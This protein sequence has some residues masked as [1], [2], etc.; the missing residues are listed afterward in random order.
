MRIKIFILCLMAPFV[1]LAQDPVKSKE[2]KLGKKDELELVGQYK[3]EYVTSIF[4]GKSGKWQ[5]YDSDLSLTQEQEL[6]YD[7]QDI[8]WMETILLKDTLIN[9]YA[10]QKDN[11]RLIYFHGLDR[12]GPSHEKE[13]QVLKVENHRKNLNN[14]VL[15]TVSKNRSKVAFLQRVVMD[16]KKTKFTCKIYDH[17]LQDLGSTSFEVNHSLTDSRVKEFKVDNDGNLY[18][19]LQ[20]RNT[21]IAREKINYYDFE[22]WNYDIENRRIDQNRMEFDSLF[23][24]GVTIEIDERNNQHSLIGYYSKSSYNVIE[25][26]FTQKFKR[27]TDTLIYHQFNLFDDKLMIKLAFNKV[28]SEQEDINDFLIKKVILKSDGGALLIGE[29]F[30]TTMVSYTA[31]NLYNSYSMNNV[32]N[33]HYNDILISSIDKHGGVVWNKIIRKKQVVEDYDRSFA[34]FKPLIFKNRIVLLFNEGISKRS[35]VKQFV[36][37]KEGEMMESEISN[38]LFDIHSIQQ[39]SSTE[40][41]LISKNNG[42]FRINKLKY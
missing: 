9:V 31:P 10:K 25:G 27:N 21:K 35:K 3:G 12:K 26:C 4:N 6:L 5:F 13:I 30:Y 37:S 1:L 33:Y 17:Q 40:L 16:K 15:I 32:T 39:I 19:L 11:D 42:N 18:V 7:D 23:I 34:S 36:V 29:S 41:L 20:H 14:D 22:L 28:K 38:E 8:L 2:L 24:N